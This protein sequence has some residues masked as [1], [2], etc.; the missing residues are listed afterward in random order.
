MGEN[1]SLEAR[2]IVINLIDR[3]NEGFNILSIDLVRNDHRLYSEAR[4]YNSVCSFE[5]SPKS[6]QDLC[7]AFHGVK[8][9]HKVRF[10]TYAILES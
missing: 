9:L 2:S 10:Q 6:E 3:L 5:H 8:I 4:E 1:R 7:K